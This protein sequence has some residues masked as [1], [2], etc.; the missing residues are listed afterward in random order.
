MWG[1]KWG[2]VEGVVSS[3]VAGVVSVEVGLDSLM[4]I[5]VRGW[6][7]CVF[8]YLLWVGRMRAWEGLVCLN[9]LGEV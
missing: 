3:C 9:V 7:C 4:D 5:V 1:S 2:S 6:G 8:L